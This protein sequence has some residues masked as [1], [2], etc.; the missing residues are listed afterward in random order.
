MGKLDSIGGIPSGFTYLDKMTF[1][2]RPSEIIVIAALPSMGKTSLK[3]ILVKML[4]Y[5][6]RDMPPKGFYFLA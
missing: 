6:E 5:Q 4:L 2:F 1:G 3:R